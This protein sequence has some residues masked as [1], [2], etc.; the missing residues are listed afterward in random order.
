MILWN[1]PNECPECRCSIVRPTWSSFRPT[2]PGFIAFQCAEE[3]CQHRW[4]IEALFT[5]REGLSMPQAFI[6]HQRLKNPEGTKR[7]HRCEVRLVF[8]R[9]GDSAAQVA[10]KGVDEHTVD[11]ADVHSIEQLIVDNAERS[12]EDAEG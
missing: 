12:R 11:Q 1:Y 5:A 4:E 6:I 7:P 3:N 10:L 8:G 9:D 2:R